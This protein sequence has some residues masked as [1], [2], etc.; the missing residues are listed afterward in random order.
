M[1]LLLAMLGVFFLDTALC[2][3]NFLPGY[4]V[5]PQGDTVRGFID[6]RNWQV[7]PNK[8]FFRKEQGDKVSYE[9]STLQ[10]FSVKDELYISASI[11]IDENDSPVLVFLQSMIR[12]NKDLL[13]YQH[14]DGRERF[15]IRQENNIDL[16]VYSS[17]TKVQ[18][19]KSVKAENKKYLGQLAF[20]LKD[21]QSI[22]SKMSGAK[23]NK[24]TL[25][26]LFRFYYECTQSRPLFQKKSEPFR[27][28]K[29]FLGGTSTTSATFRTTDYFF[30]PLYPYLT[31]GEF[32]N[33]LN[34]SGGLFLEFISPRNNGRMSSYNELLFTSFNLK[35]QYVQNNS[36][37]V[38]STT[39]TKF[40]YSYLKLN[41]LLRYKFPAGRNFIFVNAGISNGYAISSSNSTHK[42]ITSSGT[43]VATQ[44]GLAIT[45]S[46]SYEFGLLGGLGFTR[47][48]ISL[49]GR[50]E[51]SNGFSSTSGLG[52]TVSRIY[53]LLG[54]RL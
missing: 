18:D 29:G 13:Y 49:E 32:S 41:T 51:S 33:S 21:C 19:G 2:Q 27:I 1:R 46:R 42:E 38:V 22:Q 35:G 12:G 28:E 14:P 50:Y 48:K 15:Y 54:Y 17:S 24:K 34:F 44:D 47:Q 25:E 11:R 40:D 37:G 3:E 7:N 6:Y 23:Y 9:P 45:N 31:D 16:L 8:V 36:P 52:V 10:A 43:V 53:F 26:E 39:T 5:M 4:L 30:A 20:Y